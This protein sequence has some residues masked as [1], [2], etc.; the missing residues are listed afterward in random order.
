VHLQTLQQHGIELVKLS[1][2]LSSGATYA[3]HP[4]T[5]LKP[6]SPAVA[7]PSSLRKR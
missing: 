6:I 4:K 2:V 3:Y 7:F 1:D 5:Q